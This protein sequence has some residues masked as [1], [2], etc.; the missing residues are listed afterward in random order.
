MANPDWTETPAAR[1]LLAGLDRGDFAFRK[2]GVQGWI[3]D[4]PQWT[5]D[6]EQGWIA[7]TKLTAM[8]D[9]AVDAVAGFNF[10]STGAPYDEA[11]RYRWLEL[12]D[13]M[14]SVSDALA[15]EWARRDAKRSA[16]A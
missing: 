8:R 16:A 4:T 9:A 13:E 10:A 14:P 2:V 12:A 5:G 6:S 11:G 3:N 7:E 15:A 1:A